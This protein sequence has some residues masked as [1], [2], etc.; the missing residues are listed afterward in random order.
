MFC[1]VGLLCPSPRLLPLAL[2]PPALVITRYTGEGGGVIGR[3]EEAL[4]LTPDGLASCV[5]SPSSHTAPPPSG[6]G[7]GSPP[8]PLR[9]SGCLRCPR[10]PLP[11]SLHFG[12]PNP[13]T[14]KVGILRRARTPPDASYIPDASGPDTLYYTVRR[15][16][17]PRRVGP[18]RLVRHCTTRRT[19]SYGACTTLYD[20]VRHIYMYMYMYMYIHIYLFMA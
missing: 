13:R 1:R 8:G 15:A 9:V 17:H 11:L 10:P 16:V 18:R 7:R 12:P 6:S 20:P 4:Y 5:P 14:V 19:V 2:H 3:C